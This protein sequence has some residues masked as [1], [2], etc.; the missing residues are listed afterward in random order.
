MYKIIVKD[1]KK[2]ILSISNPLI[3]KNSK[4]V[5]F[6]SDMHGQSRETIGTNTADEY[7][8]FAKNK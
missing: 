4:Y 1:N 5:H 3:I 6:W 2:D 7:F 8:N